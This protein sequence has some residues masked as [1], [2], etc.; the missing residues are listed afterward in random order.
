[1]TKNA[2]FT[3]N[4]APRW[5]PAVRCLAFAVWALSAA[6]ALAHDTWFERVAD[7]KRT[8]EQPLVLALGTGNQYP[9]Y[10]DPVQPNVVAHLACTDARGAV[11]QPASARVGRRHALFRIPG[12]EAGSFS[13]V[14]RLQT[15][16]IELEAA[17]VDV[18]FDD[19]Q[20]GDSLRQVLA[21]QRAKGNPFEESYLKVARIEGVAAPARGQS[22]P[23]DVLRV[24][25]RGVLRAG[26]DVVFE[27]QRDGK[28]LANLPVQL[29]HETTAGGVWVRTDAAGRISYR[30]P[31]PGRWLLRG[32]DLRPPISPGARWDSRFI[33]YTFEV[34]R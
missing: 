32:V 15:F 7:P 9:L 27:V 14:A 16:D 4:T 12:P 2:P 22:E 13:C 21:Q 34:D 1:M 33:A 31:Q 23:L 10:E 6:Q 25:P 5:A 20:A 19:I 8:N 24:A 17:K 28:P 29:L 18:Y 30:L 3:L 11:Y 26:A